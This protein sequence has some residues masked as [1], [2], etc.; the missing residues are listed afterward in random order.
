M[1]PFAQELKPKVDNCHFI[2]LKSYCSV[3]EMIQNK[4]KP[5]YWETFPVIDL[6]EDYYSDYTNKQTKNFSKTKIQGDK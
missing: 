1:T 6:T 4:I 5:R 2:K 3:Q